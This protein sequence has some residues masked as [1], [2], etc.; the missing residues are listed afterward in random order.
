MKKLSQFWR[1]TIR[2]DGITYLILAPIGFIGIFIAADFF[3]DRHRLIFGF[4]SLLSAII[5]NSIVGLI[6]R[7]KFIY[8]DL[9]DLYAK[10]LN[11][12]EKERIKISL[13]RYPLKEGLV[14]VPRWVLG[15]PSTMLFAQ[16]F[17]P[18]TL[19]QT[20]WTLAMG[21]IL[22]ILGFYSNYFN[23][24]NALNTIFREKN[25]NEIEIDEKH[26][27][28][29]GLGAKLIGIISSFVVT[30]AFS[31]SYLAFILD[32]NILNS[33]NYLIYY[34]GLSL[35]LAYTLIAF[36][37]IFISSVK[38]N[39]SELEKVVESMAEGDLTKTG[40]RVTSDEIGLINKNIN[41][42]KDYLKQLVQSIDQSSDNVSSQALGLSSAALENFSSIEEVN[43]TIEELASG[44]SQQAENTSISLEELNHLG[45]KIEFL[46]KETELV[47]ENSVW[48][49][50]LSEE[51]VQILQE[52]EGNFMTTVQMNNEVEGVFGELNEDSKGIGEIV[53]TINSIAGQTNLLALNASI[54]AAR[55]GEA[56]RGFSVVAEEIRELAYK[57]EESTKEIDEMIRKIQI[58]ISNSND[59][60]KASKEVIDLTQSSLDKTKKS[61]QKNLSSVKKSLESLNRL[62]KEM[63]Q[64]NEDKDH[65]ID[66]VSEVASVSQET[67]AGTEEMSASMEEQGKTIE[68]MTKMTE[69]LQTISEGLNKELSA[70]KLK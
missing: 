39:L 26:Y 34:I 40:V 2:L 67:A 37:L 69:N 18:I 53:S 59:K 45:S 60:V 27:L 70:F 21:S 51:T 11:Q 48:N 19:T 15:F 54:E 44:A 16:F 7:K 24:E 31:Y 3:A 36:A 58:H 9:Q 42:M 56:G 35:L 43:K 23:A 6:F 10:D 12:E 33:E 5:L 41:N 61:N 63:V 32:S 29:F 28:D 49:S 17:M 65:L 30:T 25:L 4:I 68:E 64:V 66:L 57:T 47:K 14:M 1:L 38:Q 46:E 13:L 20:L 50:E 8:Q 55:A 52:L 22:A 62:M